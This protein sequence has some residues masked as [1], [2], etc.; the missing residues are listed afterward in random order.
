MVL[1][2]A[3]TPAPV[4]FLP[5]FDNLLLSHTDRTRVVADEHRPK[6]YLP[7]LRVAATILVDGFV[8]GVWKIEKKKSAATL[9]IEPFAPLTKQ[10]RAA[11]S[12]EGERLIRFVESNAKSYDVRFAE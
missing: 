8:G 12:D 6:V 2:D 5:E 11:L 4:R 3:D 10:N 7:A 9:I 1:P